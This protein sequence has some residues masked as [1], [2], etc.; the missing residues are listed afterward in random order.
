MSIKE[1]YSAL[2]KGEK[3][4]TWIALGF[5]G[6]SFLLLADIGVRSI[7][8]NQKPAT[9]QNTREIQI[10]PLMRGSITPEVLLKASLRVRLRP[11]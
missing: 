10:R 11:F 7:L 4:A 9:I 1:K 3:V 2:S 6:A 5:V 8:E